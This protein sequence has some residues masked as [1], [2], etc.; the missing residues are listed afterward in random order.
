MAKVTGS[1]DSKT[2]PA[3][4][5]QGREVLRVSKEAIAIVGRGVKSVFR[6]L[7]LRVWL[8]VQ[9]ETTSVWS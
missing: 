9:V 6:G 1:R 2:A 7:F 5:D 8:Q 4:N 3:V